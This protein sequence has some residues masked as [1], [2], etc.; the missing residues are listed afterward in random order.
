MEFEVLLPGIKAS[1]IRIIEP[2]EIGKREAETRGTET[3][4]TGT[5]DTGANGIVFRASRKYSEPA[6]KGSRIQ[7]WYRFTAAG[8]V[9]IPALTVF[10][11]ETPEKVFFEPITVQINPAEQLPR[12]ALGFA[13]G[14]FLYSDSF[15]GER[16]QKRSAPTAMVGVP[17]TL[18]VYAQYAQEM[19]RFDWSLPK[20]ALFEHHELAVAGMGL[21]ADG[22]LNEV[23]QF[24]W[25]SLEPG[26]QTFPRMRMTLTAKDGTETEVIFPEFSVNFERRKSQS[27]NEDSHF[28]FAD[29]F[30]ASESVPEAGKIKI[31]KEDC[32]ELARLYRKESKRM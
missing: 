5:E 14:V 3:R 11:N 2:E 13:N 19:K 17:F 23:A 28:L 30:D 24:E 1:D 10:V 4:A 15:S 22:T 12:I 16:E 31:T 29:A 18:T 6:I 32:L 7:L 20:N 27:Q 26:P 8:K 9:T 25:T 21:K